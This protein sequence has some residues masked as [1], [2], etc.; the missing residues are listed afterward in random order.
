MEYKGLGLQEAVHFVMKERLDE[1]KAG[2]IAVSRNGDVA[3]G[4]NT[5]GMFRGCATED[6]FM[7]VGIWEAIP[8]NSGSEQ[9]S[10]SENVVERQAVLPAEGETSGQSGQQE[11]SMAQALGQMTRVLQVLDQNS[12]ASTVRLDAVL[13]AI[14]ASN[15]NI[16]RIGQLL[17]RN[18]T[19]RDPAEARP[20]RAQTRHTSKTYEVHHRERRTVDPRDPKSLKLNGRGEPSNPLSLYRER[21]TVDPVESLPGEENR[22]SRSS[23]SLVSWHTERG[24]PSIPLNH[25]RERRTID[26]VV[27][28]LFMPTALDSGTHFHNL[29]V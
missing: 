5:N 28:I 6:G 18:V 16:A 2:L 23:D 4:F 24:E 26:P 19:P 27:L 11:P 20:A 3:Y 29:R 12:H 15:E 1:G 21:R 25:Y 10:N 14:T 13:A 22:R 8:R 9:P 17:T 7:E